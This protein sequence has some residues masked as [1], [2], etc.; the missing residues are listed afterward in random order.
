MI[1]GGVVVVV[2]GDEVVVLRRGVDVVV[3]EPDEPEPKP[4]TTPT[5]TSTTMTAPAASGHHRHRSARQHRHARA[6]APDHR[7]PGLYDRCEPRGHGMHGC[8]SLPLR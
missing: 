2:L 3:L 1:F 8:G 5:M 7:V 6:L 4:I